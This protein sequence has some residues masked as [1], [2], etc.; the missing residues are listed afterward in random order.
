MAADFEA[1]LLAERLEKAVEE[2]LRLALLRA[3]ASLR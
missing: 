3:S 1:A 2:D